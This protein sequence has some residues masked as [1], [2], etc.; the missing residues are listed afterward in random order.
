MHTI[1]H[2]VSLRVQW[3]ALSTIALMVPL[4]VRVCVQVCVSVCEF[5]RVRADLSARWATLRAIP[6]AVALPV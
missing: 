1:A 2:A 3:V 5:V 4:P 6:T